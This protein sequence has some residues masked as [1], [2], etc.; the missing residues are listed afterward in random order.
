MVTWHYDVLYYKPRV[1][2][3]I[4]IRLRSLLFIRKIVECLLPYSLLLNQRN[5]SETNY[6]YLWGIKILRD[7]KFLI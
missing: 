3:F 5:M 1:R 7:S 4:K 2:K 6:P